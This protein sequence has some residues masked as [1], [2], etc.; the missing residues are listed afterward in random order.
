MAEDRYISDYEKVRHYDE[1]GERVVWKTQKGIVTYIEDLGNHHLVSIWHYVNRKNP[2]EEKLTYV[3]REIKFRG[4]QS[5]IE[6]ES[7]S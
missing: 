4:L 1:N 3:A 2:M 7:A 5:Q 6:N